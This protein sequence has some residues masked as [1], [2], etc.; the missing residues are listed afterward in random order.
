MFFIRKIY[1]YVQIFLSKSLIYGQCLTRNMGDVSR[2]F[3]G[4]LYEG[5]RLRL[6][7]LLLL[8]IVTK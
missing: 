6:E 3:G 7:E 2:R 1:K 4:F 8:I 5:Y